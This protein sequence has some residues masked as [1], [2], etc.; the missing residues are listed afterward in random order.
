MFKI[1]QV[2]NAVLCLGEEL[3]S[4]FSPIQSYIRTTSTDS[5]PKHLKKHNLY[6]ELSADQN[7]KNINDLLNA[8]SECEK[9]PELFNLAF[10]LMM[11]LSYQ[12][13][14]WV[15]H[16]AVRWFF[17]LFLQIP[18]YMIITIRIS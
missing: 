4:E 10:T 2:H 13:F 6:K 16:W 1:C 15:N 12:L 5:H 8:G 11:V 17:N 7:E 3:A 18:F 14:N 9:T